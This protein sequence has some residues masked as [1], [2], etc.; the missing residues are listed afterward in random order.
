MNTGLAW[1]CAGPRL[2]AG[3]RE[4]VAQFPRVLHGLLELLAP[5]ARL[6]E[7]DA[8]VELGD[9]RR[10]RVSA[11][12]AGG[13]S[14]DG[15]RELLGGWVEGGPAGWVAAVQEISGQLEWHLA[16]PRTEG[17]GLEERWWRAPTAPGQ[18]T[19]ALRLGDLQRCGH[20]DLVVALPRG[21]WAETEDARLANAPRLR[22]LG[23]ALAHTHRMLRFGGAALLREEQVTPGQLAPAP[24]AEAAPA[25]ASARVQRLAIDRSLGNELRILRAQGDP[26][27][28]IEALLPASIP[29]V[30]GRCVRHGDALT[31]A[32]A[33]LLP[34]GP[35]T[36]PNAAL[37][38]LAE[39]VAAETRPKPGQ[40]QPTPD[41]DGTG[42]PTIPRSPA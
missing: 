30:R 42:S 28:T 37:P 2:A 27:T 6:V 25:G 3:P 34:A 7:L 10:R 23:A 31:Q 5:L 11:P 33:T 38:A 39:E 20:I 26:R 9:G 35:Y 16:A 36:I 4:R 29:S 19:P 14:A 15:V 12:A 1:H 24:A 32:V 21:P 8:Y 18:G 13:L 22:R 41:G 17:T 40:A